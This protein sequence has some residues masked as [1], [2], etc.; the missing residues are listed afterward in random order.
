VKSG[1]TW[2]LIAFRTWCPGVTIWFPI[3]RHV[4]LL[5]GCSICWIVVLR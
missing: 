1:S 4:L 2:D 3:R 5:K